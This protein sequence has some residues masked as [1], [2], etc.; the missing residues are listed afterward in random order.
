MPENTRIQRVI[1]DRVRPEIDGGRFPVKRTLGEKVKVRADIITDGHEAISGLLLFRHESSSRWRAAPLE[2]FPNDKWKASFKVSELGRYVYTLCAWLDRFKSWRRDLAK[3]LEV[4]QDVSVDLL[5]GAELIEDALPRA[6]EAYRDWLAACAQELRSD[7]NPE[8]RARRALEPALITR[9]GRSL[10][11]RMHITF[12]PKKLEVVVEPLKARFSAWYELFPRSCSPRP[13]AHG[14]WA[15]CEARLPYVSSMGFDVLYLPPIH[16][17]GTTHRKG[18]NNSP[19]CE[20]G[21]PGSPWAIGA[22]TGGHTAVHPELGTLDDFRKFL[23]RAA[24]YGLD[25]AIDLAFQCSPDHPYVREHPE[26]FRQR[27]DGSIQYAENPPKKYEDIYPLDFECP[28]RRA[29][30]D[31]LKRVVLF[32]IEQGVR[33]FR[34]D[35]PHTKPFAFWEWLIAEVKRYHPEVM[36]LAEAFTRPKVMHRLAKLGFSQSYTYFAWRNAAWEIKKYW[37]E[38]THT[39]AVEFFRPN[40]WPNTPDILTEYLQTGGPPAFVVRLILAATLG[41][42]YGIYG[43]AFELCENHPR[44]AGGEEYLNSEKYEIRTWDIESPGSLKD[45][46]ARVNRIRRDNA[47]LQGDRSLRFHPVDNDQLICYSKHSADFSNVILTVVNLDPH[48]THSGWLELPLAQLGL[49]ADQPFQVHDLLSDARY[50]WHSPRG[51]VELNP[52]VMPAHIFRIR[53]KLRTEQ[54][55]DYFM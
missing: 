43:P 20:P 36:F 48:H 42:N 34:V 23:R 41:A 40:L 44:E 15:D 50:L 21:D 31:E 37:T 47:A 2:G 28:E 38:L 18:R 10:P 11:D 22:A 33:I 52:Q 6:P 4:G 13:G 19:V 54:D 25:V 3:R 45:L 5:A 49:D 35:N 7:Q 29:L 9:M 55:F 8:M 12:Y 14:T 1:I 24:S 16:P 53:K 51:Y 39:E 46:I 30:M 26:W 32:W 27:P 17:I